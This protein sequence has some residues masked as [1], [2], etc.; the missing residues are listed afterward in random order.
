MLTAIAG[1]LLVLVPLLWRRRFGDGPM[2]LA[3]ALLA[4]SPLLVYYS[5]MF[6]H[7]SLLVLFGMLALVS[8]TRAPRYGIPGLFVGLMFATKESFAIS[9]HRM[10]RGPPC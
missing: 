7:E 9:M 10:D 2:L 8:L 3:A 5:R 1:T 6:I 4:T